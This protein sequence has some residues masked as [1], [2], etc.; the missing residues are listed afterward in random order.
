MLQFAIIL[1]SLLNKY[2]IDLNKYSMGRAMSGNRMEE[3]DKTIGEGE[4]VKPKK[5]G[6]FVFVAI[7]LMGGMFIAPI[8]KQHFVVS[9]E[10]T[11]GECPE[12]THSYK[13]SILDR[14]SWLF[15]SERYEEALQC[16][17]KVLQIDP[18]F[19]DAWYQE[20]LVFSTLGVP[21]EAVKYFDKALEINPDNEDAL[22]ND[23][24]ALFRLGRYSEA[25]EHFNRVLELDPDSEKAWFSKGTT[26]FFLNRYE[27]SI[28]CF[29]KVLE[30]DP[31]NEKAWYAKGAVLEHTG[32]HA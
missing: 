29:D 23:G 8:A 14:C 31:D 5:N 4:S 32:S 30:L 17:D 18:E 27:E 25:V 21:G 10:E 15:S 9:E 6:Q 2:S 19:G 16:F 20:G 3:K 11:A 24:L 13:Q 26:L 7:L 28:E 12:Y 22:Y 1:N